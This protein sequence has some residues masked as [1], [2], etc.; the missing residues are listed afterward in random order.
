MTLKIYIGKNLIILNM[1]LRRTEFQLILRVIQMP[2]NCFF[3]FFLKVKF[4]RVCLNNMYIIHRMESFSSILFKI[5]NL[6]VQ[7]VFLSEF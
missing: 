5:N 6:V 2:I 7:S 4:N 1:F 3:V